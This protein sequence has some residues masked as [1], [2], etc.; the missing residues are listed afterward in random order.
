MAKAQRAETETVILWFRKDLRT[1]DNRALAA[2]VASGRAVLPLYILEPGESGP[3]GEA[4]AWWLHHSL[5]ALSDD[6]KRLGAPLILRRGEAIDIVPRLVERTG[7]S[8]VYWN[9]RYDPAGAEIDTALEAALREKS[10]ETESFAGALLHEPSKVR[11]KTGGPYRVYTPFWRALEAAGEPEEPIEAPRSITAPKH[12]PKSDALE[13]LALLPR[14]DWANAFSDL[15]TPGEKA[16]QARLRHFLDDLI[17]GYTAA[18]ENTW[19][20][21]TSRLS[22]HLAL[23]ELSPRRVFHATRGLK[24]APEREVVTFRKELVWREFAYHLL[25]HNPDMRWENLNRKYDRLGWQDHSG[26][27]TAWTKGLTG[28][29]I[30][31]AGMRQLWRHGIMHNRVRMIT[32]SFL[33]KDLLIDWRRGEAWFRDTLVDAD[34][35]SNAM[36]WQWVAGC[37]AD[38]APFFRVFNPTTQGEKFDPQGRYVREHVPE[39]AR[40]PDKYIHRPAEAPASVLKEAGITLGKTYPSPIVDHSK[41]RDRA[42]AAYRTLKDAA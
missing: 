40:L 6:L 28:Y 38:A 2:A 20:D 32:G 10:I 17:G 23:G 26:D 39:L 27:F 4:Q 36:N 16:A 41:A 19:E 33:V 31:D 12:L 42:L 5:A 18:R 37:G 21:G 15:W 11:T 34:P 3:L 8:A 9:R 35:A 30:V 14:L 29:P 24:H 1:D 7:A 25:V 22:P 13:A